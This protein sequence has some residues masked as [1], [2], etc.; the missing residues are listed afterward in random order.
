MPIGFR[1]IFCTWP[2]APAAFD[3]DGL[4]SARLGRRFAEL[5]R[6]SRRS[7]HERFRREV[8]DIDIAWYLPVF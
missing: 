6:L 4:L 7:E 3:R 2:E 5:Y 1:P 8:S